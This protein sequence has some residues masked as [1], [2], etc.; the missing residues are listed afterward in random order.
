MD[1][2]HLLPTLMRV[3]CWL[4]LEQKC[5]AGTFAPATGSTVCGFCAP[6]YASK[7]GSPICTACKPGRYAEFVGSTECKQCPAG[8]YAATDSSAACQVR[9]GE[10]GPG[11]T[12]PCVP[13]LALMA[14]LC[15]CAAVPPWIV[16]QQ[17]RSSH[18]PAVPIREVFERCGFSRMQGERP[19]Y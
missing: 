12:N 1:A 2:I 10:G 14:S 4:V 5:A 8:F 18:M 6:G 9:P 17:E 19:D 3:S 13:V 7:A 11:A 15:P 16:Q